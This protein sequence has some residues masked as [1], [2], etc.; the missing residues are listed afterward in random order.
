M[1]CARR[2]HTLQTTAPIHETYLRLDAQQVRS[3]NRAHF[4]AIAARLMRRILEECARERRYQK[5]GGDARRVSLDEKLV[6]SPERNEDL[7][8]LDEVPSALRQ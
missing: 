5:R 1:R 7:V 3:R 2:E 4:F 8:A 6:I